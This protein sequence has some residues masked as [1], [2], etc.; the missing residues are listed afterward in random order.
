MEAMGVSGGARTQA[1]AGRP[2]A[3]PAAVRDRALIDRVRQVTDELAARLAD[4]DGVEAAAAA[5]VAANPDPR[6]PVWHPPGLALGHAGLALAFGYLDLCRP[7]K[8][9]DYVS[10]DYL[11]RAARHAEQ[12]GFGSLALF[13]GAT[14]LA[15]ATHY[16]SRGTDYRRLLASID[17]ALL[18]S[19]RQQLTDAGMPHGLASAGFDVI[20]GFSG[21]A[22]YLLRRRDEATHR[23][24]CDDVLRWLIALTAEVDGVPRWHTPGP[25]IADRMMAAR[26]PQ[27]VLNCGLAHGIAGPLAVLALARLQGVRLAGLTEAI[28]RSATWLAA[29]HGRDAWGVGFPAAVP[30][31]ADPSAEIVPA[32]DAW[33]YGA[34]GVARALWLAGRALDDPTLG[35]FAVVAMAGVMLRPVP[36]RRIDGPGFCHGVAGLLQIALRFS[37]DSRERLFRDGA[38]LLT[39]QLLDQFEPQAPLGYRSLEVGGVRLDKPGVLEGTAGAMLALLAAVS[40]VD[41]AWDRLFLLS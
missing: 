12:G 4:V 11:T 2:R 40:R 36:A 9:W 1:L 27:G 15:F 29:R 14:G 10:H 17:E 38:Q 35:M 32:R 39:Q 30:L 34:P 21:V 7:R 28:R 13:S 26:H 31:V 37:C 3:W 24:L 20:S 5:A 18:D 33:C 16:L 23:A 8:G 6:A 19:L 25:L 41:P 22:A